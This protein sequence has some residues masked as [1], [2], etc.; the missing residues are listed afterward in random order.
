MKRSTVLALVAALAL[1]ASIALVASIALAQSDAI[2]TPLPAPVKAKLGM[3]NVPALSPLWLLPE[4]AA[5]YNL[6][7]ETV[8][9]QRFADARTALASGDLDI[10][11]FGPQD[12]TLAV[13]QGARS[14]V[15]VA[16]VGSG[17][18][19][20]VVRKGEDVRDWKEVAARRIGVGA[21]SISWLKFAASVQEHGIDYGKLRVTNIVGGGANYLKALQG[22]EI[23]LAV[24]WQPFCAQGILDG[25]AQYPAID[26]NRSQ[27]VGGLI[28]VLAV[29]RGFLEKHRDAVQR[30]VVAYLDVLQ[31]A[32]ANPQ[33]WSKIYA[34]KAGL[35]EPVA[36]ESIRIT[37][38]DATLPMAS[39]TRISRFL[40]DNGVI[41]RDVSGEIAQHYTY[42]FLSKATGK[43]PA[44]LGQNL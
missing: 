36:A 5:K 29:N 22:K 28:A 21:G 32:Q 24:V 17:N 11:A 14:L 41:T 37:R 26:H 39:I 4:Y 30:L 35:P 15:G 40:S 43:S 33:R 6:Q 13:A 23:D 34:E 9:F 19:C 3:L 25:Y 38:L 1:I 7:I 27:T 2:R 44:E 16:G 42:E 12:I 8:M 18:D 20:L 31:F 10:T